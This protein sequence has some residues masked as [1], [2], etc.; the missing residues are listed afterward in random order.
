VRL[1]QTYVVVILELLLIFVEILSKFGIMLQ[2]LRNYF[3]VTSGFFEV[4]VEL[5]SS[6][7][8]AIFE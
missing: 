6:Y 4:T 3:G 2:L 5:F 1:R 7:F 8:G